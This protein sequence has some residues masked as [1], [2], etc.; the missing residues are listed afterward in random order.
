MAIL[1]QTSMSLRWTFVYILAFGRE[2]PMH[3]S[4]IKSTY[5]ALT[6]E[7][8]T[9]IGVKPYPNED[10]RNDGMSLVVRYALNFLTSASVH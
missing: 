1:Q 4:V 6:P 2:I 8:Q 10:C 3:L 5:D 7:V 9:D